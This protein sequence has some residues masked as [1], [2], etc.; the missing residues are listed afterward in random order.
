MILYQTIEEGFVGVLNVAQVNMFVYFG[1]ET[2]ILDP[3][4]LCLFFNG[5]HHF[6]KQTEQVE[7]AALFHAEGATFVEQGEFE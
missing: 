4:A 7:A 5:F 1:F 3:R 6:W 2:L